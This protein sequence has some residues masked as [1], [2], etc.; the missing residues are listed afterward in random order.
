[1]TDSVKEIK[2]GKMRLAN[3][4]FLAP[5]AGVNCPAFLLMC[6]KYGA[7]LV[8]TQMLD[9]HSIVANEP[10]KF[11]DILNGTRPVAVQLVGAKPAV[12]KEAAEKI[13]GCCEIIDIN[14]GCPDADVLANKAGA[15]FLKH[16]EQIERVVKAVICGTNKPIT[17]KIR[18]G[19]DKVNGAEVARILENCGISAIAIHPR[20]KIQQFSGK[21]DWKVIKQVKE[22]VSIPVIGNGDV[23]NWL[24]AEKMFRLTGC[25]AIMIGRAAIGNPLVFNDIIDGLDKIHSLGDKKKIFFEFLR[26]YE[27]QKRQSYSELRQHAIWF[28]KYI[29]QAKRIK[30]EIGKIET[31][32]RL[33]DYIDK[34]T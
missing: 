2:I 33:L 32:E 25:D 18:S 20:T 28:F 15:F 5:M 27:Q 16:P 6:K 1:M 12:M 13:E 21:A 3:N 17:A 4:V 9:A 26:Y 24:H 10:E 22:A 19:W 23:S 30:N 7:G 31:R 8:Y 34:L 14:L 11:L 29:R